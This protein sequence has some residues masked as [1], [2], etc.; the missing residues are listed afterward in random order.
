[1]AAIQLNILEAI[2]AKEAGMLQAITNADAKIPD[3]SNK[4]W[5]MFKDWLSGWPPGYKFQIEGFRKVAQIR[6][7]PD[8]PTARAFGSLAVRARKEGLVK[9]NGP[10]PTTGKTAHRCY[11]NEWEKV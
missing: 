2:Q 10:K 4:A 1:M 8:P 11:S 9:S 6:G 7:L 3:W 5:E